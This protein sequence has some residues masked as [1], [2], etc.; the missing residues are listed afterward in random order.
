MRMSAEAEIAS[1]RL[2]GKLREGVVS[3]KGIPY[4]A[5]TAGANRFLPPRPPVP[6]AEVRDATSYIAQSPQSR[7]GHSRRPELEHFASP[8]DTTPESE[9]C[10]RLNVWTPGIGAA[11]RPVMVWL[12]GGGFSFG[13]SNNARLEGTNLCKR[14]DVVLVTVNQRLNIFGHLDLSEAI[15][16]EYAQSGNAGTL[17][18]VAALEWVRDNIAVFGG[19]PDN[20]TI[21]GESGGGGKVSTLM[22]MPRAQGL[23]QR[24]I[25]QSGA[26]IRLR[27]RERALRLTE[28][29]LR[30]LEIARGDIAALQSVPM[31]RLLAAIEPATKAIGPSRW[32]LLDR[33]PFGPVVDGDLLPRQPFDP[34]APE[35]SADIPLIVGDTKDEATLYLSQDDRVWNDTLTEDQLRAALEPIAGARTEQVIE[36]YRRLN[37]GATPARRLAA[38]LTDCNF[39]IRSLLMAERRARQ[40]WAPVWMY[41]FAWE[42]P[43]FGGRLRSP[44]AIDVPFTFDTVHLLAPGNTT[45]GAAMLAAVMSGTWAAFAHTGRPDHPSLPYWPAYDNERRA[46]MILDEACRVDDDPGGETRVLWQEIVTA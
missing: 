1:G 44:H 43:A 16:G 19:N 25:V 21:F 30:K 14:G 28:A 9:D 5:S 10:L 12:H 20:V 2:R 6:W 7:S 31:N 26:A 46:T 8:P 33:Y 36:T 11:K 4:G 17:D 13:S 18:M 22:A 35:V 3:F 23:F 41:S 38:T 37:P 40:G 45:P 34:D 27:D 42:T 24:A 32:P 29:V 39:R 15:G